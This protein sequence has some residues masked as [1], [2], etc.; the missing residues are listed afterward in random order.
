MT[1]DLT[2]FYPVIANI[3]RKIYL[4][5]RLGDTTMRSIAIR[6]WSFRSIQLVFDQLIRVIEWVNFKFNQSFVY[7][8]FIIYQIISLVFLLEL[9]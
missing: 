4:S 3:R 8:H 9:L 2:L 6:I 1:L 5:L 7:L